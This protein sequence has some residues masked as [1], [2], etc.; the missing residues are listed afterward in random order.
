MIYTQCNVY[1]YT[2]GY[3]TSTTDQFNI[4]ATNIFILGTDLRFAQI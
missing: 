1:F 4:A 2:L 3:N